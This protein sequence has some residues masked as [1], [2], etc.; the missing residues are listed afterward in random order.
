LPAVLAY[1]QLGS[2][3]ELVGYAN[4]IPSPDFS[5]LTEVVLQCAQAGDAIAS[6]LL[7]EQGEELAYLVRLVIRRMRRVADEAAWTPPIAYTGSI[8]QNVPPVR[9]AL[10]AAVQQ[11]FPEVRTPGHA[12]DPLE[13]ALWRARSGSFS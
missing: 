9:D 5:K 11:E 10:I 13:G 6:T 3:D 8:L 12:V 2:V 7:R 4:A 1:W